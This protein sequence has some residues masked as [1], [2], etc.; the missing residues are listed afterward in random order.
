MK[1]E[2]LSEA[3]GN[4]SSCYIKEA[5]EYQA[6]EYT[7]RSKRLFVKWGSLVACLCLIAA[8]VFVALK[9][10]LFDSDD[11]VGNIPQGDIIPDGGVG[12]TAPD[13]EDV[14]NTIFSI[15]N[16]ALYLEI[17]DCYTIP[18]QADVI[19]VCITECKGNN[20]IFFRSSNRF[21]NQII[22]RIESTDERQ[23]ATKINGA[24]SLRLLEE[25]ELVYLN[26]YFDSGTFIRSAG[27]NVGA[28]FDANCDPYAP[29]DEDHS[30]SNTEMPATVYFECSAIAPDL[31]YD[32]IIFSRFLSEISNEPKINIFG[33]T[34]N[35]EEA[36]N[37]VGIQA[38]FLL[39]E[40]TPSNISYSKT[41]ELT[42]LVYSYGTNA[43]VT[44]KALEYHN[45]DYTLDTFV[46]STDIIDYDLYPLNAETTLESGH[47]YNIYTC[48]KN[49]ED[50]KSEIAV[51]NYTDN[52]YNIF[53]VIQFELF[54]ENTKYD[55]KALMEQMVLID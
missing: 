17:Y 4:I 23:I 41:N 8:G 44:V 3:I 52:G 15:A 20:E 14:E 49:E 27:A 47:P 30:S 29:I 16:G 26:I 11:F 32:E 24:F 38:L 31:G 2:K 42:R 28:S 19:T 5:V 10:G 39:E 13:I 36:V 55:V 25:Q 1:R 34:E 45:I 12:N 22:R 9:I 6:E 54:G 53:F 46:Y 18:N 21:P 43:V 40:Y 33:T 50:F 35:F 48:Y 51:L 7:H 37:A